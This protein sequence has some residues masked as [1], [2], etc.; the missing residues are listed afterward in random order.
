MLLLIRIILLAAFMI[1]T[2]YL[3]FNRSNKETG[4]TADSVNVMRRY[5]MDG[6]T[7]EGPSG[8]AEGLSVSYYGPDSSVT[9]EALRKAGMGSGVLSAICYEIGYTPREES[10][11]A[12]TTAAEE[13]RLMC[14]AAL[15]NDMAAEDGE[16]RI[17]RVDEKSAVLQKMFIKEKDPAWISEGTGS[18]LLVRLYPEELLIAEEEPEETPAA[19]AETEEPVGPEEKEETPAPTLTPTP[20]PQPKATATPTPAGDEHTPGFYS[21]A[22][23]NVRQAPDRGAKIL[24]VVKSGN[25]LEGVEAA[26]DPAW[27]KV[28]YEG[29]TGYVSAQYVTKKD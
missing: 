9:R 21:V 22:D 18:Y 20:T 27:Y 5:M 24:G 14:S 11:S 1:V 4:Y 3:Y 7:I 8:L 6:L 10:I 13:L 12:D 17:F 28:V 25:L 23:L 2:A 26:E 19:E 16:L 15:K 29:Q